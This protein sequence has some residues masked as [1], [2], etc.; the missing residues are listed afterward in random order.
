MTFIIIFCFINTSKSRRN[1]FHS[2]TKC[3]SLN[4]SCSMLCLN[5]VIHWQV[6]LLLNDKIFRLYEIFVHFRKQRK[7]ELK[8]SQCRRNINSS[9]KDKLELA[10]SFEN[11]KIIAKNHSQICFSFSFIFLEGCLRIS[12]QYVDCNITC[13]INLSCRALS[14]PIF[15]VRK[16]KIIFILR[17]VLYF[18]FKEL[19]WNQY[20][21]CST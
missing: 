7:K 20:I 6:S 17:S 15:F 8:W 12:Y 14:A 1:I 18:A 21:Y 16:K 9:R 13:A 4:I 5:F 2:V 10:H 19:P 11:R 3:C